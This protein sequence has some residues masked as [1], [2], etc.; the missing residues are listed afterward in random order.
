MDYVFLILLLSK[1]IALKKYVFVEEKISK[2]I[3]IVF[4]QI[5]SLA[6]LTSAVIAY[7]DYLSKYIKVK[8][9]KLNSAHE[10]RVCDV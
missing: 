6:T 1:K 3:V 7:F 4:P 2:L 10:A 8:I 5:G 9:K